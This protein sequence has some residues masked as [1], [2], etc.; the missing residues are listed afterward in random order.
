MLQYKHV[1][2]VVTS[3]LS[4]WLSGLRYNDSVAL[5]GE[6]E[7]LPR[8]VALKTPAWCYSTVMPVLCRLNRSQ[9]R[10]HPFPSYFIKLKSGI[11]LCHKATR[12]KNGESEWW[13]TGMD[14]AGQG[15]STAFSS[16]V[17][18]H[19]NEIQPSWTG[20]LFGMCHCSQV[21]FCLF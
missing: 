8:C 4:P 7:E 5:V 11:V 14:V 20:D 2:V 15:A 9:Q 12:N 16:Y 13:S 1:H 17:C 21:L 6:T 18:Y 3:F 10:K 19:F